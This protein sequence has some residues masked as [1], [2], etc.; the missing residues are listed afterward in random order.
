MMGKLEPCLLGLQAYKH[1]LAE[2]LLMIRILQTQVDAYVHIYIYAY[3]YMCICMCIYIHIYHERI[4]YLELS[5]Y[6]DTI[7]LP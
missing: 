2:V 7:T 1:L 4:V 3:L 5:V 6:I